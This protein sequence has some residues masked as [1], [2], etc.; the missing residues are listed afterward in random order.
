MWVNEMLTIWLGGTIFG[1]AAIT[2]TLWLWY[3][4]EDTETEKE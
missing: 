1:F 3:K 2:I 4:P